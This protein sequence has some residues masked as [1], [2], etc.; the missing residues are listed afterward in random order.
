MRRIA[1]T[2]RIS[3]RA[4]LRRPGYTLAV[5]GLIGLGIGASTSVFS[6]IEASL[7]R[8]LPYE[9]PEELHRIRSRQSYPDL[10]DLMEGSKALTTIG[11]YNALQLEV[12]REGVAVRQNAAI[13][14]GE[15]LPM[16][17]VRPAL[18]RLIEP[19]DNVAGAPRVA[20]VSH[21]YWRRHFTGREVLGARVEALD[22]PFEI[23]GVLAEDFRLPEVDAEVLVPHFV[24]SPDTA[25][26]RGVHF[27]I[28]AAR[29]GP[30]ATIETAQQEL[31]TVALR[32]EELY[33]D[34]NTGRRYALTPWRAQIGEAQR[35]ALV[36]LLASVGL[37]LIVACT[38]VANLLLTRAIDQ[39][40]ELAVQSALG[41]G[42][43][44]ILW[45]QLSESVVVCGAGSALGVGLAVAANRLIEILAP[46]NAI[47]A[48]QLQMNS[49]VL[50]FSAVV[51]CATA[52]GFSLIPA[53]LS[54]RI[55]ADGGWQRQLARAPARSRARSLLV[56][57]EMATAFVLLA[58]AG[59]LFRTGLNLASSNLGFDEA[60]LMSFDVT[61][62]M[63][64]SSPYRSIARRIAYFD[65]ARQ[66]L[67]AGP[68]IRRVELVTDLPFGGGSV[69]HNL[70]IEGVP[71]DPGTEPE[72][73]YR[74]VSEGYF[75]LMNIPL[76]RGRTFTG[77]PETKSSHGHATRPR[78][79]SFLRG[80]L[81]SSYSCGR[82]LVGNT[83]FVYV[84]SYR[85]RM[86]SAIIAGDVG[87]SS[88]KP[89]VSGAVP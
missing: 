35:P 76:L 65:D 54:S 20:V 12:L 66:S 58:G 14:T 6:V 27:L 68:G 41:A 59:L 47:W 51:A 5:V 13:V 38:N 29:L 50:T 63:K 83:K 39:E 46:A 30:S 61:L 48:G 44:H 79:L 55:R 70:A 69:P 10:V 80:L 1:Q 89:Y 43:R 52:I 85:S 28:A 53:S 23:V 49:T 64:E 2:F 22:G 17:G 62:S 4:L 16:L 11:G 33:P 71:M 88:T 21:A 56:V 25:R 26:S 75:E 72:I 60:E 45:Q 9:S 18:G 74:G 84:P 42:F 7:L 77:F 19:A 78:E 81:A 24:A 34:E 37:L 8:P 40:R 57:A 87:S 15:L 31:D 32:L 3:G 67:E 36:A 82:I 73:F 86:F